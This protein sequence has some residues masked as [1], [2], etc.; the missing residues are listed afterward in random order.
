MFVKEPRLGFVKT[1]LAKDTG[2]EF[3]LGL[4]HNF[5]RDLLKTLKQTEYNFSLSAFPSLSLINK[6]F[7]DFH[8]F[9][10]V[11]GDLGEKMRAAFKRSFVSEEKVLLIGSDTPHIPKNSF[12]ESFQALDSH[13]VVLGRSLDGGY[14]LIGFNKESFVSEVFSGISWSSEKVFSQTMDKLEGKR[15]YLLQ[16]LNDID[17][18]KDLQDFYNSYKNSYFKE[19]YTLKFLKENQ[20]WKDSML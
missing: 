4:F 6:T 1:R 9:L 18:L 5:V 3:A 2:D 19:S 16:E 7:G 8:N 12:K 10:Q 17:N 11:E 13:D 14:Y 20:L 15:V